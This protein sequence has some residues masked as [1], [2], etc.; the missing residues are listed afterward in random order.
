MKKLLVSVLLCISVFFL[1]G[2]STDETETYE[3]DT[4]EVELDD[5]DM[6]IDEELDE[7]LDEEDE[8]GVEGEDTEGES[9]GTEEMTDSQENVTE[10]T[11]G[12]SLN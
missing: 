1:F 4:Y 12:S 9:E 6:Y 7:E 2:C 5:D 10:E 3:N 11:S 8:G